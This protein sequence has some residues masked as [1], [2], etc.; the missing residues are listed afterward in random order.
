MPAVYPYWRYV[1][2][3]LRALFFATL[4]HIIDYCDGSRSGASCAQNCYSS[5]RKLF[6]VQLKR[7]SER[8][9]AQV[10]FFNVVASQGD[11]SSETVDAETSCIHILRIHHTHTYLCTC[12]HGYHERGKR[13]EYVSCGMLPRFRGRWWVR[14][15]GWDGMGWTG[16]CVFFFPAVFS[17]LSASDF[18]PKQLL[19]DPFTIENAD[20]V[21]W[22]NTRGKK[23]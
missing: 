15:S 8:V 4:T 5:T 19:R 10:R 9:V 12:V 1:Y 3:L 21:A 16:W 6:S 11:R 7:L 17:I 20:T 13:W 23:S 14:V 18:S 2:L 22:K